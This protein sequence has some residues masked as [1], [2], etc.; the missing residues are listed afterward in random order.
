MIVFIEGKNM[1]TFFNLKVT[2]FR[3]KHPESATELSLH[4]IT[5][6]IVGSVHLYFGPG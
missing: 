5:G 4:F 6:N 1:I 2:D 3:F